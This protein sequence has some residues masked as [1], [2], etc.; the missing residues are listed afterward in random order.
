MFSRLPKFPRAWG[1][2][3]GQSNLLGCYMFL[4]HTNILSTTVLQQ[5]V[6]YT[7][8]KPGSEHISSVTMTFSPV[9]K[10]Q[11][12]LL[13]CSNREK[14]AQ[15]QIHFFSRQLPL[16]KGPSYASIWVC[17][18]KRLQHCL[19][20]INKTQSPFMSSDGSQ[21]V[22]VKVKA[23][24]SREENSAT[25]RIRLPKMSWHY[26]GEHRILLRN[27]FWVIFS[28]IEAK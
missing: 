19:G 21:S 18:H 20:H 12:Q 6:G 28:C 2:C 7:N 13:V 11:V 15:E 24:N 17:L 27:V 10:N 25:K 5:P 1:A 22:R 16:S 4:S 8:R 23:T 9:G 26:L 14:F 3:H